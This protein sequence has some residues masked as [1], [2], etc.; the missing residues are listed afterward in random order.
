MA[1]PDGKGGSLNPGIKYIRRLTFFSK[2]PQGVNRNAEVLAR[3][4]VDILRET[5]IEWFSWP[6][7]VPINPSIMWDLWHPLPLPLDTKLSNLQLTE[8]LWEPEATKGTKDALI[9]LV[10]TAGRS[11]RHLEISPRSE[12]GL[13]HISR[14][15][16]KM[17]QFGSHLRSISLDLRMYKPSMGPG[18][19]RR[20][21]IVEEP[22]S[23]L[24]F[25][26]L[27]SPLQ[28]RR[29]PHYTDITKVVLKSVNL[30]HTHMTFLKAISMQKL[31]HLELL[32]CPFAGRFLDATTTAPF[33]VL[34]VLIVD[35]DVGDAAKTHGLNSEKPIE[36]SGAVFR[37]LNKF[38]LSMQTLHLRLRGHTLLW[39]SEEQLHFPRLKSLHID[40]AHASP[41]AQIEQTEAI[42]NTILVNS[43][44]QAKF[45]GGSIIP[46]YL[47]MAVAA[48]G[49]A[50]SNGRQVRKAFLEDVTFQQ[51]I[52]K[53]AAPI[54]LTIVI[55]RRTLS[56]LYDNP[57]HRLRT[58][59]E[60]AS[61]SL[62]EAMFAKEI[63]TQTFKVDVQVRR[64]TYEG[65][66]SVSSQSP[67]S[68]SM[69]CNAGTLKTLVIAVEGAGQ[70]TNIT[71]S[72][73]YD[74]RCTF[75][76][77]RNGTGQPESSG[78]MAGR[79]C[80]P[81][82]EMPTV[83]SEVAVHDTTMLQRYYFVR[84]YEAVELDGLMMKRVVAVTVTEEELERRGV[85]VPRYFDGAE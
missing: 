10:Q 45:F 68:P 72:R 41:R 58:S 69:E 67:R 11:L 53:Y 46:F 34:S 40:C 18:T 20:D 29:S 54:T 9:R 31:R 15:L 65:Q 2:K 21:G 27:G 62:L 22:V 74:D 52:L 33:T 13:E 8:Q 4:L 85:N 73:G 55:S 39:P 48:A 82:T 26:H 6:A 63:A 43:A 19:L 47:D 83:P 60:Q 59:A 5:S 80:T 1:A 75:T 70:G 3:L 36:V 71:P 25:K 61:N 44:L 56:L 79:D 42:R 7:R 14:L 28:A 12:A 17:T 23:A 49:N 50:W 76:P 84:G 16:Q 64:S 78:V 77:V 57:S 30:C 66:E 81:W 38:A 35:H 51:E 37:C 24:I 32:R